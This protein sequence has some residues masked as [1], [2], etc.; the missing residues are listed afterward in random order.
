MLTHN[1]ESL[2]EIDWNSPDIIV[3]DIP[4]IITDEFINQKEKNSPG[5]KIGRIMYK[6]FCQSWILSK[7]F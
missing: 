5:P 1:D 2:F 4:E 3:D 7:N 6:S